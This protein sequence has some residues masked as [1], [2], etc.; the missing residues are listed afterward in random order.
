MSIV[1][2]QI[3]NHVVKP[4]QIKVDTSPIKGADVCADVYANI[5]LIA[6]TNSGKTTVIRDLIE[7][8]V[9][10]KTIVVFFVSSIYNDENYAT[11]RDW[12]DDHDI[13]YEMHLSINEEGEDVLRD[14]LNDLIDEAKEKE[15]G[16]EK[17]KEEAEQ[18]N[19]NHLRDALHMGL[20]KYKEKHKKE[21]KERK[22][23]E[24]FRYPSFLFV[25]DDISSELK[26]TS[27]ISLLKRARHFKIKTITSTQDL[28]DIRP[29][30]RA[31]IKYWMIFKG[32]TPE[33]LQT[34]F[35]DMKLNIPFE[36]FL[37]I[38]DLATEQQYS[39]LYVNA[40]TLEFR[41]NFKDKFF[42]KR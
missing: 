42:I 27:Y 29:D 40:R 14:Y 16:K 24:K 9:G 23:K 4:I 1:T 31:Q 20:D 21:E 5:A 25:F 32:F 41:R 11:I 17:D 8:C 3:N 26:S 12:L 15:E 36:R 39:F 30:A 2:K 19:T 22:K 28:K 7:S 6:P 33:R 13:T 34:I 18:Q 38:Y 35:N 10:K 37:E